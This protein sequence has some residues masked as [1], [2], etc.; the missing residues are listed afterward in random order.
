[1][2]KNYIKPAMQVVE[3]QEIKILCASGHVTA[4]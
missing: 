1:M 2:K 4:A 3:I